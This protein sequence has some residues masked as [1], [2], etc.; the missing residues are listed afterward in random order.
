MATSV[1]N[2]SRFF[3]AGK[4]YRC[5]KSVRGCFKK[6]KEYVP[7]RADNLFAWFTNDK[8][9]QHTWPQIEN[10]EHECELFGFKPEDMDPRLFFEPVDE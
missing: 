10:I 4:A 1:N 2:N 5:I 3:E 7:R 6:D 8:G 9:E